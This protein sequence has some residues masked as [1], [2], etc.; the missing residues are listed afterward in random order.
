MRKPVMTPA[1]TPTPIC[2][3]SSKASNSA[4]EMPRPTLV[5]T[6]AAS[7]T[8]TLPTNEPAWNSASE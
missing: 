8:M 5:I 2:A 4:P 6:P 7:G 1:A 3:G